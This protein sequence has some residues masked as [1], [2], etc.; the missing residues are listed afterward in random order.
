MPILFDDSAGFIGRDDILAMIEAT[1]SL[2]T[3][4][5]F[6]LFGDGGIGK[7]YLLREIIT[8]I[9][10]RREQQQALLETGIIDLYHVRYHQ[11]IALMNSIVDRLQR[12]LK[13][14]Q[15]DN[16]TDHLS[17]QYKESVRMYI[18]SRGTQLT[19]DK[20]L[21]EVRQA[22]LQYY[23]ELAT[24][25]RIVLLIDTFEKLEPQIDRDEITAGQD[26]NRLQ[27]WLLRLVH[28]LPNTVTILAGRARQ[29][30]QD[31][32]R[33]ILGNS[34]TAAEVR[35]LSKPD[36]FAFI[37]KLIRVSPEPE[38]TRDENIY[39]LSQGNPVRLL[40]VL[41]SF[42][43]AT[44]N[45]EALEPTL[46]DIS[47]NK[48][49]VRLLKQ[50]R[51]NT[52]DS[53][54][55]LLNRA[56]YLRKGLSLELLHYFA[57]DSD[58]G[59]HNVFQEFQKLF[60]V[61]VTGDKIATLHDEIYDLLFEPTTPRIKEDYAI[62]IEYLDK[63]IGV[64]RQ[65]IAIQDEPT[66]ENIQQLQT[67]QIERLFYQMALAPREGYYDYCELVMSAIL[68]YDS[69]Y[70]LQLQGELAR[71]FD[72]STRW[73]QYYRA[74]LDQEG[75]S[76]DNVRYDQRVFD[77]YRMLFS[78]K[79]GR[80]NEARN[81]LA[82]I[83]SAA[84]YD[85]IYT[86][87]K[88]SQAF[89]DAAELEA[90]VY[91]R[92]AV[93]DSGDI[94]KKYTELD[95]R[96]SDMLTQI[97]NQDQDEVPFVQFL[98][99][100]INNAW[101]YFERTLRHLDSAIK[102]YRVAIENFEKLGR[103]ADSIRAQTLNN[104]GFAMSLQGYQDFG[105]FVVEQALTIFETNGAAYGAAITRNTL[106]RIYLELDQVEKAVHYVDQ[107]QLTFENFGETREVAFNAYAAGELQR[108][109]ATTKPFTPP[110][111]QNRTFEQAIEYY[112][113][114]QKILDQLG[115]DL[116]RRIEVR[117]GLGCAYRS[118]GNAKR[119]RNEPNDDSIQQALNYFEEAL[120]MFVTDTPTP[121]RTSILEDIAVLYVDQEDYDQ[122]E[123]AIAK[124]RASVPQGFE[125]IPE[126]GIDVE[127]PE[128]I[129]QRGFWLQIGQIEIQQS[130]CHL[131][132][133]E[134]QAFCISMLK[135][136]AYI[137]AFAPQSHQMNTLRTLFRRYL[138]QVPHSELESLRYATYNASTEQQF[139]VRKAFEEMD[140]LFDEAIQYGDLLRATIQE[141]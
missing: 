38:S 13:E 56:V 32:I 74:S 89:L 140:Y 49:F 44:C 133:K 8:R 21:A 24:T 124:S 59:L 50:A 9:V 35:P 128:T 108:W 114:A 81:S 96:L 106:A 12:S 19:S 92:N 57:P 69:A 120:G 64:C 132:R 16:Q 130:L 27:E 10:K 60:I 4:N 104:L 68:N 62:A 91:S 61:K 39:N 75:I 40:L 18:R 83:K 5:Q 116:E 87:R 135:A 134:Y 73:G 110:A 43:Q 126:F 42:D 98:R 79:K 102:K 121:L 33:A 85:Q 119:L 125:I 37:H 113:K 78:S 53:W 99:G 45:F 70:D 14:L 51:Q 84:P 109:I 138:R 93:S 82:L 107:A 54:N 112:E 28:D 47:D 88:I 77:A 30:Q 97:G 90:R 63:Q 111:E 46:D 36:T 23:T 139:N 65:Q 52:P 71:F 101:G 103:E 141:Y 94:I 7:T 118:W 80:Y 34:C 41:S 31:R 127:N 105:A 95:H 6:Y 76:W 1:F 58:D 129:E 86:Q 115:G 72:T 123:A 48:A 3:R 117:Q 67:F 137:F 29:N 131:G 26:D 55:A 20:Q 136:F 122:A 66:L 2:E 22:F 25:Y 17:S 11:P 15:P 100:V